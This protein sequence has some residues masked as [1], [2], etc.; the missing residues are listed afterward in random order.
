MRST[1]TT[2]GEEEDHIEEEVEEVKTSTIGHI[3]TEMVQDMSKKEKF[4]MES[5]K[6]TNQRE[7]ETTMEESTMKNKWIRT[8]TTTSTCIS[9]DPGPK[10]FR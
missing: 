1:T 8:A 4:K 3:Q 6:K 9:L 5:K 7:K 2:R 10:E